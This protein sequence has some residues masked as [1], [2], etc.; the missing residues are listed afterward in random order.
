MFLISRFET[1]ASLSDIGLMAC[2]ACDFVYSASFVFWGGGML[3][4]F[5]A[6][7]CR[8]GGS[9]CYVYICVLEQSG[10]CSY[11]WAMIGESGPDSFVFLIR[12]LVCF[13]LYPLIEFLEQLLWYV[14]A[15]CYC[16]YRLPFLLFL[17]WI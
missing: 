3:F 7:L 11:F 6:L 2:V 8:C 10:D 4:L 13:L 16:L 12:V 1:K 15:F 17:F 14:V 9:E 5:Y